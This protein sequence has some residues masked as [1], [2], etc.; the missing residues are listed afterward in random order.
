MGN[1]PRRLLGLLMMVKFRDEKAAR[2]HSGWCQIAHHI[3]PDEGQILV[4]LGLLA[5]V[6]R[7]ISESLDHC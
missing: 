4:G 3:R 5:T 7:I 6:R 2:I 1:S